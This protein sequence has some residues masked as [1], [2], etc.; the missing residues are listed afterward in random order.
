MEIAVWDIPPIE[1]FVAGMESGEHAGHFSV[2]KRSVQQCEEELRAGVVDV[3]LLPTLSVLQHQKD[4]D[5]LPA[6]AFST[7]SYPFARVVLRRDLGHSIE[8][9]AFDPRNQQERLVTE[10][11]LREHY[12]I[13][14][15]FVARE[16][17]P[18]ELLRPDEDA[19]LLVGP[20]VPSMSFDGLVLDVGREWFELSNYPMTWGLFAAQRGTVSSEEI[21]RVRDA[22]RAS[23][24]QRDVW[25]RARET[26]E[27]LHDFYMNDLR[28]RLD[29]LSI[30]GLTEFRQ[31]LFYY[32]VVDDVR[33]IPFIYLPDDDQDDEQKPLL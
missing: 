15:E 16:F 14:P 1:L 20:D 19:C 23:E 10:I 26:S 2:R 33:E 31:Y 18:E 3:A 4:F 13:Q 24:R 29:D 8:R 30:A 11:I 6:V 25:V 28:F 12:R 17:E 32:D 5:V 27:T 22:V 7:W 9:V 21:M